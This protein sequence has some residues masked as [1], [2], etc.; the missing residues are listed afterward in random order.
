MF[1]KSWNKRFATA[2]LAASLGGIL[3]FGCGENKC[4]ERTVTTVQTVEVAPPNIPKPK[5][6]SHRV[7]P[8]QLVNGVEAVVLSECDTSIDN[9]DV[10]CVG[11]VV[12]KQCLGYDL[13][14]RSETTSYTVSWMD[15]DGN[16]LSYD[17]HTSVAANTDYGNKACADGVLT[18]RDFPV[19]KS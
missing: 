17:P 18:S 8:G 13:T 15:Q 10:G 1:E 7:I 11:R 5:P 14:T 19:A 4:A 9:F 12:I 6:E 3:L 16:V 2:T